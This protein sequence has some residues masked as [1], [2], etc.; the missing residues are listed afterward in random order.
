[1]FKGGDEAA[2]SLEFR[3]LVDRAIVARRMGQIELAGAYSHAA[4]SVLQAAI[5]CIAA[6]F[7]MIASRKGVGSEVAKRMTV[8]LT[9]T[10]AA[11]VVVT[12]MLRG[13]RQRAIQAVGQPFQADPDFS[14]MIRSLVG[15]AGM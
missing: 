2:R 15:R 9:A 4:Q 1:M 11:A 3:F 14:A 13:A 10:S 8:H 6:D 7:G 12:W 5:P